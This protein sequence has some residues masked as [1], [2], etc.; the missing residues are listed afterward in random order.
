[1]RFATIAVLGSALT[2]CTTV[3]NYNELEFGT[4]LVA[5]LGVITE[6]R[7]A[8][9]EGRGEFIAALGSNGRLCY[10]V[11]AAGGA[12]LGAA[13]IRETTQR[14]GA[15]VQ[16][17][18]PQVGKRAEACMRIDRNLARH[19]LRRPSAFHVEFHSEAYEGGRISGSLSTPS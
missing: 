16:L 14:E 3:Q 2:A 10:K 5:D 18:T 7:A 11:F 13:Q 8:E 15:V 17:V 6:P 9:P 19:I 12:P 1:M 4:R